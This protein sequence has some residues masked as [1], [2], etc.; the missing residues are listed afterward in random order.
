MLYDQSS[1]QMGS[2]TPDK[3]GRIA[4]HEGRRGGGKGKMGLILVEILLAM[5]KKKSLS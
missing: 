5:E 3:V 4:R 2:L 1:P